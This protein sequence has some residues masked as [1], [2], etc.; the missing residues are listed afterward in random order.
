[1]PF[2]VCLCVAV[3]LSVNLCEV[4]CACLCGLYACVSVYLCLCLCASSP[5][6]KVTRRIKNPN[7][8]TSPSPFRTCLLC[9]FPG[10]RVQSE[11]HSAW[12]L[13]EVPRLLF[14]LPARLGPS[15]GVWR[16]TSCGAGDC[17]DMRDV[18]AAQ[19]QVAACGVGVG[20][21][22]RTGLLSSHRAGGWLE[23]RLVVASGRS[24]S[25]ASCSPTTLDTRSFLV[26]MFPRPLCS[27]TD[28]CIDCWL[29]P[30]VPTLPVGRTVWLCGL[31]VC[32]N[33]PERAWQGE[34]GSPHS[35]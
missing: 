19:I 25:W 10:L 12:C 20:R 14:L 34:S 11:P 31:G 24:G 7:T 27:R 21:A 3:C 16:G 33:T 23:L 4:L 2:C 35:L 17:W 22:R 1:M 30:R 32:L 29:R 15:F 5:T 28:K 26:L 18:G 6:G 13:R 9:P 8:S